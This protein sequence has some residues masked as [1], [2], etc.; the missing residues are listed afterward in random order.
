MTANSDFQSGP[1]ALR[2]NTAM[3]TGDVVVA[4][5]KRNPAACALSINA[6]TPGRNCTAPDCT[7]CSYAAVFKACKRS[8]VSLRPAPSMSLMSGCTSFQ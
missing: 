1:I 7:A 4:M 2:N 3:L 5:A 6:N 8:M